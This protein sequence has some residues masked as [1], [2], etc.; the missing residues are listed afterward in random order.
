MRFSGETLRRLDG[1]RIATLTLCAG[2]I[3]TACKHD[4]NTTITKGLWIAN[5]TNVFEY[6]PTQLTGEVV[7][8]APHL[9]NSSGTLG[10]PQG[11]TFDSAG[12]LWVMDPQ[13]TVNGTADTPALVKFS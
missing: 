11:V 9:T 6:I 7:N 10:A 8:A 1:A 13:A 3:L 5:G 2:I 12:N 4:M